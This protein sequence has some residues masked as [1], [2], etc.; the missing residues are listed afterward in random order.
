MVDQYLAVLS[1]ALAVV[2]LCFVL[3]Q[4]FSMC[5]F[6]HMWHSMCVHIVDRVC[7]FLYRLDIVWIALYFRRDSVGTTWV[8]VNIA[9]GDVGGSPKEGVL[10]FVVL[11]YA[12]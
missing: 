12:M 9:E 1:F 2:L 11:S 3:L 8:F 4:R 10:Y 7:P 5:E 6:K